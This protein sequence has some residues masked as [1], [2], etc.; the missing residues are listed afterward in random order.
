MSTQRVW[1]DQKTSQP[2]QMSIYNEDNKETVK[3]EFLKFTYDP[4]IDPSIF[5]VE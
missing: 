2:V 1:I 5:S 3:I 4:K